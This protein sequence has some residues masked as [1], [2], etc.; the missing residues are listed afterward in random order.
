MSQSRSLVNV[1]NL[2]YNWGEY[3]VTILSEGAIN[4][5]SIVGNVYLS[6]ADTDPIPPI[7]LSRL[8]LAGSEVFMS[9]NLAPGFSNTYNNWARGFNPIVNEPPVWPAGLTAMTASQTQSDVLAN[10]GSRPLDRDAVDNRIISDVV[11]GTGRLIDSQNDVG[12]WP[13]LAQNNRVLVTPSNPNGDDDGDGYTNLEEWLHGY[14]EEVGGDDGTG[15]GGGGGG[16]TTVTLM[17]ENFDSG[18]IPGS[19]WIH[20]DF[21]GSSG[22]DYWDDQSSAS[23]A[24]VH[25]GSSSLFCADIGDLSGQMY[26]HNMNAYFQLNN[27]ID[28][29]GLENV[30]VR[31]WAWYRTINSSDYFS[32]EY[33]SGSQWVELDRW[34]GRNVR[35]WTEYIMPIPADAGQTLYF[36]WMFVSNGSRRTEGAYI[37]DVLVTALQ[38]G[39]G[40]TA[41]QGGDGAAQIEVGGQS[42]KGSDLPGSFRLEQNYPNPFNPSTNIAFSLTEDVHT[43]LT[44]VDLLGR[45]VARLVDGEM[46]AGNHSVRFSGSDLA[47]GVYL[48]TLQAGSFR[49]TKRMLLVK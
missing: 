48:Y 26:D 39:A 40:R 15:G 7:T 37:D 12:G 36:R 46:K 38:P 2:T 16:G 19:D 41:G 28:I 13:V 31:F 24:R 10:A 45:E 30:T 4:K 47:N 6:G 5:S 21:N 34:F 22:N 43:T 23:G 8:L 33:L 29:S 32:F 9:D 14:S 20:G 18:N 17:T 3:G 44:V 27:G 42:L 35:E 25:S 11:N 1:N 49:E